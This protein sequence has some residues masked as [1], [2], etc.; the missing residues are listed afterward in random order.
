MISKDREYRNFQDINLQED[1]KTVS[2]LAV[3]F[4][5]PTVLYEIGGKEYREVVDP[6]AFDG[7][8]LSDVVL[9]VDHE[10]KPAAKTK[11]QT[12]RLEVRPEGLYMEADLSKNQTGRELY[13]DIRNGFY[14]KMSYAYSVEA[15]EYNRETRTRTL[16]K[17]K[18]LYDVSAV[19]FP[20]Y[21]QTSLQARSFFEAEAEKEQKAMEIAEKRRRLSAQI[22]E[23]LEGK[24][25]A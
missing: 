9:N 1:S 4:N 24:T 20:A 17:V 25:N 12:L 18:R 8:D 13:E 21:S 3:V 14:D 11:N 22:T 5:S 2:G 19:T 15:D 16:K 10:G 23:I 7:V 6:G